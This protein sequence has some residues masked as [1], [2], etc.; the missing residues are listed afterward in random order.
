MLL[1]DTP[2]SDPLTL[3]RADEHEVENGEDRA[4]HENHGSDLTAATQLQG[5]E[6]GKD[7]EAHEGVDRE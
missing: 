6:A 7:G 2:P 4:I 1:R 3:L 5:G